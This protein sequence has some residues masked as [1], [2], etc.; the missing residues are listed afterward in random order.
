[1]VSLVHR[2][3]TS[4]LFKQSDL[5]PEQSR[6]WVQTYAKFENLFSRTRRSIQDEMVRWEAV[7]G[8]PGRDS[9]EEFLKRSNLNLASEMVFNLGSRL[10]DL[11]WKTR[12]IPKSKLTAFGK[13]NKTFTRKRAPKSWAAWLYQSFAEADLLLEAKSWPEKGTSEEV[14]FKVGPITVTNQTEE[15]PDTTTKVLQSALLAMRGSGVPGLEKAI[16]GEIFFVGDIARKKTLMAQYFPAEDLIR[17]LV[18]KRYTG[19]QVRTLIH[20]FGH[21][22]WKKMLSFPIQK[23]W[24]NWD[25]Q[26]RYSRESKL[27]ERGTT[28]KWGPEEVTVLDYKPSKGKLFMDIGENRYISVD[29]YRSVETKIK[30]PTPYA[31]KDLEEHFCEAL[32]LFC[33]GELSGTHKEKFEEIIVR[34]SS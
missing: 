31:S 19:E 5:P 11:V 1:M 20:E 2:I 29:D 16:Y 33:L 21:R 23:A 25:D 13:T 6:D 17:V 3:A 34:G 30:F 27:P 7:A 22:Y 9:A 4:H 24:A 18:T 28:F 14:T 32:S 10:V 26:L 12:E 8:D 15:P